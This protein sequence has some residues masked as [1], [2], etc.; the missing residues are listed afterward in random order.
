MISSPRF[1]CAKSAL[2]S[3]FADTEETSPTGIQG[4]GGGIAHGGGGTGADP[5]LAHT[6]PVV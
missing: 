3:S 2:L 4:G 5:V 1:I 6:K